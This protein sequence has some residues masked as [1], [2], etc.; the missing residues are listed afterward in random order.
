[1]VIAAKLQCSPAVVS[2]DFPWF[3]RLEF[4]TDKLSTDVARLNHD[5]VPPAVKGAGY[6]T[7][8]DFIMRP[9]KSIDALEASV[10]NSDVSPRTVVDDSISR[11]SGPDI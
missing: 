7:V 1:M 9:I 6:R 2:Q 11:H 5:A 4:C 8:A 10:G 3:A